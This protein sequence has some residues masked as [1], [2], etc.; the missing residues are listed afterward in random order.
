MKKIKTFLRSAVSLSICFMMAFT[1]TMSK[2]LT[3]FAD[4][5]GDTNEDDTTIVTLGANLNQEERATVLSLLDLTE[6]DLENCTVLEV[7]N[8][9]EHTYLDD[10]LDASVIGTR[11]LSSIK[12]NKTEPG[13]GIEVDT[14]N[15]NYCTKEM[16][17]NALATAGI[18]DAD[19]VVVGPFDISGTAALVGVMKAYEEM[20]GEEIP[21]EVKDAA[22]DELVTT[23]ELSEVIGD[24]EKATELIGYIKKQVVSQDLA[25]DDEIAEVVKD[26]AEQMDITLTDDQV[27]DIV[28]MMKK[29]SKLDI[30]PEKLQKQ[31]QG[32]YDKIQDLNID[33]EKAKGFLEKIIEFFKSIYEKLVG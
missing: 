18:E 25:S 20:T 33:T 11:A 12:L 24:K 7:T 15:I 6:G 13:D 10:Y 28:S 17:V 29:I 19:V 9:D 32:I 3:T 27:K 5:E 2:P 8:Q 30:D 14:K 16:Y 21:E 23:G 22:T 1:L 26:A 4:A 31:A